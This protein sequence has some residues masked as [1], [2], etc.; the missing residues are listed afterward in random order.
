MEAR[1]V[2]PEPPVS[3][4][5]ILRWFGP[6]WV[7]AACM[8]GSGELILS[9][10]A[11]S[12]Y[13]WAFLW[14]IPLIVLCKGVST[15]AMLRYGT[16]T[17][18]TFIEGIWKNK[19]LKWIVPYC[20]LASFLY[21]IG[22][23]A[24]IGVTAGTFNLLI[25]GV[26]S[27]YNWIF[28]VVI[29]VA[30]ICLLGIYGVLE[31]IMLAF[32]LIMFFGIIA[33]AVLI[34]PPL[35]EMIGGLIPRIPPNASGDIALITWMGL[36]GWLGAG[37]GPT[38]GYAWWAKEKGAGMYQLKSE[39]KALVDLGKED[40]MRLKGWLKPVYLDLFVSYFITFLISTCLY[41]S[42]ATILFP[43]GLHPKGLSLV[44]TLSAMFTETF[45]SWAYYLFLL[46]SLA[47]L[48]SSIIGVVDGLS[49]ANREFIK[50]IAPSI[51]RKI[52]AKGLLR[53]LVLVA[54]A[55]PLFFLLM[56][57]KPIW[58]LL[59]SSLMFA[60]AMGVI[61]LSSTY[62]CLKLPKEFRPNR[63]V[64]LITVLTA[65]FMVVISLWQ[66]IIQY[67]LI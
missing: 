64:I 52:S 18:Q 29:L 1:G 32:I 4:R 14:C 37:W 35:G 20:M 12:L 63:L 55:I 62:L 16:L 46:G 17:G 28:V 27:P 36:W 49:R 26:L 66:F 7:F 9:T 58:L 39:R 45:G 19:W 6:G 11:A 57:Q 8:I 25:P 31:K 42:G 33:V 30:L 65:I 40:R 2:I 5:D 60:P 23:G 53:A 44:E 13:G 50:I 48:L 15:M 21:L 67:L 43:R 61:F 56:F 38:L 41:I 51:Y 3:W 24:H 54:I 22:I 10:R 59:L 47:L 34:A